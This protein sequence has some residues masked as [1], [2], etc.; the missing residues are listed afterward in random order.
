MLI[1]FVYCNQCIDY[2][3]EHY[4]IRQIAT[5]RREKDLLFSATMVLF[6]FNVN[7]EINSHGFEV[8]NS[9]ILLAFGLKV[10]F[11]RAFVQF[12]FTAL[13]DYT[14]CNIQIKLCYER[15]Q[16]ASARGI[17]IKVINK[18]T[19]VPKKRPVI[20]QRWVSHF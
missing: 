2:S 12:S 16:P 10:H 1:D 18:I 13:I 8:F 19:Q 14:S 9:H 17:G 6:Q 4:S 11:H 5:Y 20:V 3:K 7:K 15:F